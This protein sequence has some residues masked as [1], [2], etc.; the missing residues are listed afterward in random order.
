MIVPRI[1]SKMEA[2]ALSPVS[3]RFTIFFSIHLLLACVEISLTTFLLFV[4]D[5]V[6]WDRVSVR[7]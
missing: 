3:L 5:S 7:V 1:L 2:S 4:D 6:L